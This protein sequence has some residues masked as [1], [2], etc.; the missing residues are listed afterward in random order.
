MAKASSLGQT[1]RVVR[2]TVLPTRPG[3]MAFYTRVVFY[4]TLLVFRSNR[5]PKRTRVCCERIH[6]RCGPL[7]RSAPVDRTF[8]PTLELKVT[9]NNAPGTVEIYIRILG[10]YRTR[11]ITA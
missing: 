9:A 7:V 1:T 6:S 5:T 4:E 10:K 11:R 3:E 8:R 2:G